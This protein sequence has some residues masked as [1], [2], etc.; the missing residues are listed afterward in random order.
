MSF[1]AMNIVWK[2]SRH[3]ATTKLVFLALADIAN[4]NG[5]CW[6]S[7]E[8]IAN[9]AN[10][11]PRRVMDLIRD[12]EAD[13]AIVVSRG[14]GTRSTNLYSLKQWVTEHRAMDAS[15]ARVESRRARKE[16]GGENIAPPQVVEGGENISGVKTLHPCNPE[17]PDFTGGVKSGDAGFHPIH[18]EPLLTHKEKEEKR[19]PAE[20]VSEPAKNPP[21]EPIPPVPLPP[22]PPAPPKANCPNWVPQEFRDPAFLDALK[23]WMEHLEEKNHPHT[24][25]QWMSLMQMCMRAGVAG[26]ILVMDFSIAKGAKNLIWDGL[27][28]NYKPTLCKLPAGPAKGGGEPTPPGYDA[29]VLK[30]F[31]RECPWKDAPGDVRRQFI[32]EHPYLK[33]LFS[34]VRYIGQS[35]EEGIAA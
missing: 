26:S 20:E 34:G 21:A 32:E 24:R 13:K 16:K 7:Y 14:Q 23:I 5:E 15:S 25:F 8:W 4:E 19:I 3:P 1:E 28:P 27:P 30:A 22:V 11:T 12:L 6:P 17:T 35:G 31:K 9:R 33:R 10:C 18:N 2:C 29:W